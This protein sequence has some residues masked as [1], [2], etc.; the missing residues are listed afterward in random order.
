MSSVTATA[1]SAAERRSAAMAAALREGAGLGAVA[2]AGGTTSTTRRSIS[3][4]SVQSTFEEIR[5]KVSLSVN[6]CVPLTHLGWGGCVAVALWD[7]YTRCIA[8]VSDTSHL[9]RT[10][11]H[12]PIDRGYRARL[13]RRRHCRWE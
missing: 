4:H 6:E 12:D 5:Q 8:Q 9:G 7:V 10:C 2:D 3:G 1:H 13:A 11:A